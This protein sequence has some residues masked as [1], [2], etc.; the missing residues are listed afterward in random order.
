M[1]NWIA[2]HYALV[3]SIVWSVLLV[4]PPAYADDI[5]P[6]KIDADGSQYEVVLGAPQKGMS[7]VSV[8]FESKGNVSNAVFVRVGGPA[9]TRGRIRGARVLDSSQSEQEVL[10]TL[11]AA[12]SYK[13]FGSDLKEY[14]EFEIADALAGNASE[15]LYHLQKDACQPRKLSR[16]LSEINLD[17]SAIDQEEFDRGFTIKVAVL[18]IPFPGATLASIKPSSDGKFR[19]E[20]ILLMGS[21]G[22]GG[23]YVKIIRRRKNRVVSQRTIP[24]VKYVGYRGKTLSLARLRGLLRGGKATFELTGGGYVYGVCFELS[25]R[26]QVANGYTLQ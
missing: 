26:R 25:R 8:Y 5:P 16:Y 19:G 4:S 20:P 2:K 6:Y 14:D 7:K 21:I 18:E 15:V 11:S 9:G 13:V 24:V 17:L 22:Y 1:F 10:Q 12:D 23:E 3:V